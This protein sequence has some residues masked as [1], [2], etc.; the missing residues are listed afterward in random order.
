[1]KTAIKAVIGILGLSVL[2]GCSSIPMPNLFEPVEAQSSKQVIK[3]APQY[4]Q[5]P[6]PS[7][8][9][10]QLI[11]NRIV[12]SGTGMAT[13]VMVPSS[14]NFNLGVAPGVVSAPTL[15]DIGPRKGFFEAERRAALKK[16]CLTEFKSLSKNNEKVAKLNE[17]I[18][19]LKK[20]IVILKE[21]SEPEAPELNTAVLPL[22]SVFFESGSA[23]VND[24]FFKTLD[25]VVTLH[26]QY[27]MANISVTG[28]TDSDGDLKINELISSA[29][30]HK[31]K[32][33]LVEKGVN[34]ESIELDYVAK[35]EYLFVNKNS[36]LKSLNRR[37]EILFN[38]K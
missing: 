23:K 32:D 5:Q 36:D 3:H 27:P 9:Q 20:E 35:D 24:T 11:N 29:R 18:E 28:F 13:G 26:N 8:T 19:K 4:Y 7:A 33:Y 25:Q 38:I 1:M 22:R 16:T 12:Y 6:T 34:P 2:T 37:V 31:V 17:H 21:V 15:K 14:H 10:Q 30:S